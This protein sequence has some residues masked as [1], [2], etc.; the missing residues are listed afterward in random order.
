MWQLWIQGVVC[1]EHVEPYLDRQPVVKSRPI[2]VEG[3][4]L[5]ND[6]VGVTQMLY[7][8]KYIRLLLRRETITNVI[9]KV[10]TN[11]DMAIITKPMAHRLPVDGLDVIR[12]RLV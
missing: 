1:Q 10:N 12:D 5:S 8:E 2:G 4:I 9:A 11:A 6:P 3:P 7:V